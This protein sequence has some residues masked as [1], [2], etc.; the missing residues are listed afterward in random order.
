MPPEIGVVRFDWSKSLWMWSMLLAGL[1]FGLPALTWQWTLISAALTLFTLCLG[2]SVGLHRG[3]IHR[4][5][6]TSPWVRAV[7]T[8]LFVLTGLGGPLAGL[9]SMRCATSG[10]TSPSPP[11][12]SAIA[13]RC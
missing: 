11:T 1:F 8:E 13:T 3:V 9:G 5:Y 6:E 2:H 7:L 12:T 4:A 10:R